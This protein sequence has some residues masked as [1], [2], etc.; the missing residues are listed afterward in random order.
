MPKLSPEQIEVRRLEILRATLRCFARRGFDATT[1][2]D[3]AREAGVAVG[4]FYLY[5]RDKSAALEALAR[6]N[7]ERT[8]E[9]FEEIEAS[10][11]APTARFQRLFEL[12]FDAVS[13]PEGEESLRFELQLWA[14]ALTEPELEPLRRGIPTLWVERLSRWLR[15]LPRSGECSAQAQPAELARVLFALL[16]G[17]LLL[18]ALEGRSPAARARSRRFLLEEAGR[19]LHSAREG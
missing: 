13:T 18:E 11:E 16:N 19:L 4:T 15:E 12:S 8:R 9:L 14:K 7:E 2:Q 10:A 6:T 5:F 17:F 3:I 1:L